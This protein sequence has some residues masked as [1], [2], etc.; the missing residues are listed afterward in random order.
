MTDK[1]PELEDDKEAER[2]FN[3]AVSNLLSTPHKPHNEPKAT[4]KRKPKV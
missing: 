4:P 2:R 1:P 3:E